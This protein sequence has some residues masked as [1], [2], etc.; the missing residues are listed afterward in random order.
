M[1]MPL[2]VPLPKMSGLARSDSRHSTDPVNGAEAGTPR[3]SASSWFPS[4]PFDVGSVWM[5]PE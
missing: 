3:R 1:A 4:V 5:V 2:A